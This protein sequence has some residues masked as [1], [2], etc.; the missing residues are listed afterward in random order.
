MPDNVGSSA[1]ASLNPSLGPTNPF[2]LFPPEDIEHSIPGRFE[3]QV[4]LYPDRLAVKTAHQTLTYE[5]LNAWANQISWALLERLGSG[6]EPVALLVEQGAVLIAATLGVLKAGKIYIPL[7]PAFPQARLAAMLADTQARLI[8]T[9]SAHRGL[10]QTCMPSGGA[11]VLTVD[12]EV[13]HL[14]TSNPALPIPPE[15]LACVLYTS[16]STGRPKGVLHNHRTI[17]HAAANSTKQMHVCADDRV[18]LFYSPSVLGGLTCTFYTLLNGAALYPFD[19]KTAGLDRLGSWLRQEEITIYQSV[20]TLFRALGTTLS[21]AACFPHLRLVRLGGEVVTRRDVELFQHYCAA[22]CLLYVGLSS[23]EMAT[24]V[25]KVVL[26]GG[27][28]FTGSVLPS[29]YAVDHMDILILDE[30]G[31]P[32][33]DGRPGEIAVKS[34]YL[35]VGYWRQP[36]LSHAVFRPDPDGSDVRIYHTGDLGRL[37]PDG[38]LEHLG[39]K[40]LQVKVRGYRVETTEIELALLTHPNVQDAVVIE[41]AEPPNGARLVAYI[42]PAQ[43]PAPASSELGRLLQAQLPTYMLPAAFVTLNALPLTLN[44]K[45]DRRALPAPEPTRRPLA[46]PYVAPR[47]PIEDRLVRIWSEVLGGVEVGVD[48]HFLELG[49]HSILAMQI[50]ARVREAWH[51]DVSLGTFLETPT[52]AQMAVVLVHMQV[53]QMPADALAALLQEVEALPDTDSTSAG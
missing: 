31:V 11:Q 21:G 44:G 45:V 2:I 6:E 14:D 34:R 7:D 32:V 1:Q 50:V 48:D 47:T 38:C 12:D 33:S 3:K 26:D 16:G 22:D 10:L 27:T 52:I 43:H 24:S 8:V 5:A 46:T 35:A 9:Q 36:E 28:P 29:G 51:L 40:D 39:R 49:G 53:S 25:C 30:D 18:T 19:V 15:G 23:T 20:A 42:V 41:H 17:L 13:T 37:W 4:L